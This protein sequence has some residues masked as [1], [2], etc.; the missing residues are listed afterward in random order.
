[1]VHDE[2]PP[3]LSKDPKDPWPG[4]YLDLWLVPGLARLL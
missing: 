1:M 3:A 2:I 4:G